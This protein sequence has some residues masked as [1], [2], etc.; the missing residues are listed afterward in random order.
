MKKLDKDDYTT[1]AHV[2]N[3]AL[4]MGEVKITE[5]D[6]METFDNH[7]KPPKDLVSNKE[8][9]YNIGSRCN[10][11][12]PCPICNKC[13]V[14]ASHL[15]TKCDSCSIPICVHENKI[16]ERMIRPTNFELSVNDEV[17]SAFKDL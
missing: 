13:R 5:D 7:I 4:N 9:M 10:R 8:E 14:K 12:D 6:F 17:K 15:Y 11:Y 1:L 16:I 2:A 3:N